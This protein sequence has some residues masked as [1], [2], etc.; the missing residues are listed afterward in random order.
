MT[1]AQSFTALANLEHA[2]YNNYAEPIASIYL[3]REGVCDEIAASGITSAR[4]RSLAN[5]DKGIYNKLPAGPPR[6]LFFYRIAVQ[7]NIAAN[8]DASAPISNDWVELGDLDDQIAA[9]YSG[10]LRTIFT[11]RAQVSRDIG[12][13]YQTAAGVN[14]GAYMGT[15]A[16]GGN[17][18]IVPLDFEKVHVNQGA[19]WSGYTSSVGGWPT[20]RALMA[21]I[22]AWPKSL[23][24]GLL[25]E[26]ANGNFDGNHASVANAIGNRTSH[27]VIICLA[28]EANTSDTGTQPWAMIGNVTDY[29]NGWNRTKSVY[30][31]RLG[32]QVTF[33]WT[34]LLPVGQ[35]LSTLQSY[36]PSG[37]ELLGVDL[38][39]NSTAASHQPGQPSWQ[40]VRWSERHAPNLATFRSLGEAAGLDLTYPEIGCTDKAGSGGGDNPY[41]I[42]QAYAY[43]REVNDESSVSFT[44]DA[45]HNS[46]TPQQNHDIDRFPNARAQLLEEYAAT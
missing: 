16:Q 22:G 34:I 18:W 39:D 13:L 7:N 10:T 4:M 2:L 5:L 6:G 17:P 36:M 32:S 42:E 3:F 35:N 8:L 19:G 21:N 46:D 38:Y 14:H 30:K 12:G 25:D 37:A 15:S 44:H 33:S 20:T 31:A 1:L 26:W 29:R 11:F 28:H 43:I 40:Q 45:Y 41:F 27:P 24:T 23:G 9:V